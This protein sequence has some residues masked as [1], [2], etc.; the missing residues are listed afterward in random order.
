MQT[1]MRP[2]ALF[3]AFSLA[4]GGAPAQ[5]SSAPQS[6]EEMLK[7]MTTATG[8]ARASAPAYSS[9]YPQRIRDAVRSHLLLPEPIEGNPVAEVEVR[10]KPDGIIA[11]FTL[12]RSSG[13]PAWDTAVLRAVEKTGRIPPDVSG[14]VPS[15]LVMA[16][17]PKP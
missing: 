16:F 15:V 10:T 3:I 11:S 4:T 8:A 6:R 12:T 14:A 17:R 13:S 7:R 1:V 5:P 2:S 9:A